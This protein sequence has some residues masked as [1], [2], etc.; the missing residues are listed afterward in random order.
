MIE[1]LQVGIGAILNADQRR[2]AQR[3]GSSPLQGGFYA[4]SSAFT[5]VDA[6]CALLP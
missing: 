3:A 4:F 5:S 1:T 6:L 2:A